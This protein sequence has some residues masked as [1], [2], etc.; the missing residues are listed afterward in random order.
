MI[1]HI[2]LA[3]LDVF[4][5]Y[6]DFE[7]QHI[8]SCSYAVHYDQTQGAIQTAKLRLECLTR[9][10][11]LFT[12]E[13]DLYHR[14]LKTTWIRSQCI[15]FFLWKG[16]WHT[17]THIHP[18]AIG[19]LPALAPPRSAFPL[20]LPPYSSHPYPVCN[21]VLFLSSQRKDL[22]ISSLLLK[23]GQAHVNGRRIQRPGKDQ[24][25]ICLL[26]MYIQIPWANGTG[27]WS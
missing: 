15:P 11:I 20:P 27:N 7:S 10:L 6:F 4:S 21:L 8:P 25:C 13:S 23:D 2:L 18:G 12:S 14:H 17:H 5:H 9:F 22:N 24:R 26:E 16:T 19:P 1:G 3:P